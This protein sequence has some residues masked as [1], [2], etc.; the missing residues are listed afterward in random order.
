MKLK[1]KLFYTESVMDNDL[2]EHILW[3]NVDRSI[4]NVITNYFW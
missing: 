4:D 1:Y 2:G 3:D